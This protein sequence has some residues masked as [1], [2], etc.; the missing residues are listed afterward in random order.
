MKHLIFLTLFLLSWTA[1]GQ[2]LEQKSFTIENYIREVCSP[3]DAPEQ[4]ASCF[5]KTQELIKAIKSYTLGEISKDDR[6]REICLAFQTNEQQRACSDNIHIFID[7]LSQNPEEKPYTRDYILKV[8]HTLFDN[9]EDAEPR[10]ACAQSIKQLMT[11]LKNDTTEENFK[12]EDHI[13]N[14]LFPFDHI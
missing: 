3:L 14:N 5:N 2:N 8:C 12:L 7:S 10:V 4:K 6:I 1:L 11:A 9:F 13:R